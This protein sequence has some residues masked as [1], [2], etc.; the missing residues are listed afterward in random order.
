MGDHPNKGEKK[1]PEPIEIRI[2]NTI[3][4]K[5]ELYELNNALEAL[6]SRSYDFNL[7]Q[8][9]V[10]AQMRLDTEIIR[11]SN[12]VL[13]ARTRI[14]DDVI[15]QNAI[16]RNTQEDLTYQ[17]RSRMQ[18]EQEAHRYRQF[19]AQEGIVLTQTEAKAIA[20][21]NAEII[22]SE[23]EA[24]I[25]MQAK[26]RAM[27][28]ASISLFVMNISMNQLVGSLK[29]FV[30]GNKEAE[31][32][33]NDLSAALNFSIAPLQAYMAVMQIS[34]NLA[35]SQKIAFLGVAASL[36]AVFFM[37]EALTAQSKPLRAAYAAI[38]TVLTIVAIA[39]WAFATGLATTETL[40]GN[41]AAFGAVA[42]GLAATAA[43]VGWVSAPGAQTQPGQR[44]KVTRGGLAEIHEGEIWRPTEEDKEGGGIT[45]VLPRGYRGTVSESKYFARE[46]ERQIR[47]GRSSSKFRKVVVSGY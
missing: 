2:Q 16:H 43:V 22:R 4:G 1:M 36:G 8:A 21:A 27:M 46:V 15:E 44:K 29:P 28:Q 12:K 34:T 37:Y 42:A 26:R 45:I 31:K 3:Y 11:Q 10:T 13:L 30:K 14:E 9:K 40:M 38:A 23:N 32:A 33:L 41:L 47:S 19:Y 17:I 5:E 35:Q 39:Q 20:Q 6:K 18:I 24:M 7:V 25:A